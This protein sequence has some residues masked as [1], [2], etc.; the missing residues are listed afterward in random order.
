VQAP[1]VPLE[2]VLPDL[3]LEQL[4]RRVGEPASRH[5]HLD[6]LDDGSIGL[7]APGVLGEVAG[8]ERRDE[9]RRVEEH[10]PLDQLRA[11]RRDLHDQPPAE[12]VAD[13]VGG[14]LERVEQVRDM[15]LDVPG[16]VPGGVPVAAEVRCHDVEPPRQSLLGE[17]AEPAAVAGNAVQADDRRG[18]FHAPF[19][20]VEPQVSP[21]RA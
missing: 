17:L 21:P 2:R 12:A 11:H 5:P 16:L 6:R 4:A 18:G 15:R 13:P 7:L 19:L 20:G 8:E 10:G 9:D 3:L 14:L 1:V